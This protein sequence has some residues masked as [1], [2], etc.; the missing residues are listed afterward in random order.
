[1]L[2]FKKKKKD[3]KPEITYHVEL[4]YAVGKVIEVSEVKEIKKR[5]A[6]GWIYLKGDKEEQFYSGVDMVSII[7]K[8]EDTNNG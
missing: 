5:I 6:D 7:I 4:A 1:M 8:E 3:D 2:W